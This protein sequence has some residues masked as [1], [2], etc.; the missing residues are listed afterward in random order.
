MVLL[1]QALLFPLILFGAGIAL[2][3]SHHRAEIYSRPL[4]LIAII[5]TAAVSI[6]YAWLSSIG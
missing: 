4:F 3:I 1:Y 2:R 5:S 6:G